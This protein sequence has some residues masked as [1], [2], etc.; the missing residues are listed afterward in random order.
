MGD[1]LRPAVVLT[2]LFGFA[3]GCDEERGN[4]DD[5]GLFDASGADPSDSGTPDELDAGGSGERSCRETAPRFSTPFQ[6]DGRGFDLEVRS[7]DVHL[8]YSEPTCPGPSGALGQRLRYVK[9][10]SAG[11]VPEPLV[12]PVVDAD[13]CA[14]VR[15][16]VLTLEPAGDS[17]QPVLHFLSTREGSWELYRR[18]ADD[19]NAPI[20][21]LSDAAS[22]YVASQLVGTRDASGAALVAWVEEIDATT[23]IMAH[24]SGGL[25]TWLDTGAGQ[26]VSALA[27]GWFGS[28]DAARP[29]L[30]YT[31][32]PSSLFVRALDASGAPAA[33][34]LP[35]DAQLSAAPAL[36]LGGNESGG[37]IMYTEGVEG[38]VEL[39]FLAL[40]IDGVASGTERKLTTA[41]ERA[42]DPSL[43]LFVTGYVAAFRSVIRD[44]P[45]R[46]L[47]RLAFMDT[48][49]NFSGFRDVL[50]TSAAGGSIALQIAVDGRIV[51]GFAE[52]DE[53]G[54]FSLEV[55]RATCSS[56]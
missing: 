21:L 39:R 51:L 9:F 13:A 25:A 2:I 22:T 47:L 41:A 11:D 53:A 55:A 26:N 50:E 28:G 24:G 46:A 18:R 17:V 52:V 29:L 45:D 3:P 8:A 49:G 42:T 34:P 32:Q 10:A 31:A 12:L 44:R 36:A 27:L 15:D 6:P 54:A 56:S 20:E 1:A 5:T 19:V 37:A 4:P 16:P 14:K 43:A 7:L 40:G 48:R 35:L 23:V 38:G 30:A 33:D